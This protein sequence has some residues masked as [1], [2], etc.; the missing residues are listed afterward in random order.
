M[1]T[2]AKRRTTIFYLAP[3]LPAFWD[4]PVHSG[5]GLLYPKSP[6]CSHCTSPHQITL[7]EAAKARPTV[8]CHGYEDSEGHL[9]S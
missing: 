7:G 1:G 4:S 2:L 5:Q 9:R 3:S 8:T 6:L